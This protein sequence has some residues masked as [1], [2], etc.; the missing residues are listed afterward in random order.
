M[1]F[2]PQGTLSPSALWNPDPAK[3]GVG[4]ITLTTPGGGSIDLISAGA[5]QSGEIAAYLQ[6]RDKILPRGADAARR[7]RRADV[8]DAVGRRRPPAQP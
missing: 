5:I 2:N 1:S 6:M 7:I 8:A 3:S 4:T